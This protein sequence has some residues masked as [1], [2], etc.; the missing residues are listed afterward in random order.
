MAQGSRLLNENGSVL[1]LNTHDLVGAMVVLVA[2][3]WAL[4]PL[5]LDVLAVPVAVGALA[6]LVPVRL[7]SRR[8]IIR[9]TLYFHLTHGRL[10]V[11]KKHP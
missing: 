9:D 7:R 10:Y 3:S 8:K 1:G 2:A 6:V 5:G 4:K 11:P